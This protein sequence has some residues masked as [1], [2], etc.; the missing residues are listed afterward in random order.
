LNSSV[1]IW[2]AAVVGPSRRASP[3][4]FT[5]KMEGGGPSDIGG[6]G[7]G[8]DGGGPSSTQAISMVRAAKQNTR[9]VRVRLWVIKA[10]LAEII[11]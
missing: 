1:E 3:E 10:S 11:R 2:G 6:G 9:P 5:K 7:G 8:Y 4:T